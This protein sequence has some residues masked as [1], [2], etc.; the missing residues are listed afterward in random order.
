MQRYTLGLAIF[1]ALLLAPTLA[2]AQETTMRVVDS[3]L[4]QKW[5]SE[6]GY[7]FMLPPK[8]KFNTIGSTLN[9]AGMTQLANFILSGGAGAI[10][11]WNYKEQQVVPQGYKMLDSMVYYETDSVGVNGT[12]HIR[13]YILHWL[14]V[15]IEV[16]LTEKGRLE[17]GDRLRAIFDSFTPPEGTEKTL[18]QWR[19]E[20][21]KIH[22]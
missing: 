22:H 1:A 3:T 6:F 17:Y 18:E 13:T 21:G 10:K 5:T 14:V 20:Y 7:S 16:L 4:T 12:I 2:S 8:A 11:I 19:Y 15:R 9:K